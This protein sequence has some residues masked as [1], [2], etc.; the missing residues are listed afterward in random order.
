MNDF[1]PGWNFVPLGSHVR[2]KP[3]QHTHNPKG[4]LHTT[5]GTS[6]AGAKV[7]Y[8][9]YPPHGI[10]DWRTREREQHIPLTRAAYA[11]AEANDDDYVAQ[12]ELVGFARDTRHWPDEAYRNI[13]EDV[14]RPLSEVFGIPPV[15]VWHGFKDE[16][17]GIFLASPNSPIRLSSTQ[18]RDFSGWLGHQ[19]LPAPDSHWDPGAVDMT[20]LLDY[21]G[22]TMSTE[23]SRKIGLIHDA[24][25][26]SSNPVGV[27]V[28]DAVWGVERKTDALLSK[29]TPES[30]RQVFAEVV[31][32]SNAALMAGIREDVTRIVGVRDE[33]LAEE[34]VTALSARLNAS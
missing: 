30:F 12:I 22:G 18:L 20:C 17:D 32:E 23:D 24:L 2:G 7:A 14:I 5:E 11:G 8:A 19:H 29:L 25:Y 27:T 28:F 16:Q 26:L 10:Y 21:A 1:I 31:A 3:Y 4:L 13:A 9:N 33:Q 6:I 15:V 34:V